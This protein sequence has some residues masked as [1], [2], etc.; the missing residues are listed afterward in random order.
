MY[1]TAFREDFP[2]LRRTVHGKCLAYLDNAATTQKPG[3]VIDAIQ[4]YY[5]ET[6]SN[7]H[8]AVHALA[9]EA[10]QAYEASRDRVAAFIHASRREEVIFTRGTTEGINLVAQSLGQRLGA[11]DEILVTQMEHHSNLVPWQ[12]LCAR[13]GARLRLIPVSDS[14][15][16]D[17][18]TLDD[19]LNE[20][21][22][23]V[24]LTHVSNLLGT[25][26]PV[27]SIISRAH[28]AGALVLIDAAQSVP[29]MPVD[30]QKMGADFLVFSAHKLCGPTGVGVLV[31]R[32]EILESMPPFL[33]GGEMIR[34]VDWQDSTYADLP[35]KFE[36]GTPHIAGVVGLHSALDYLDGI[37]M[38]AIHERVQALTDELVQKL[39]TLDGVTIYGPLEQRGGAVSFDVKG[40]H[41]HD[42][43]QYL[44]QQGVA[45][46]AGHMCCQPLVQRFGHHALSRASVYFYNLGEEIDQLIEAIQKATRFFT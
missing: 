17:L 23:I 27:E 7:V 2:I 25:L 4:R 45:I 38:Q 46:R 44:D 41:P 34:R 15:I 16:L 14:G 12:M 10:T 3:Q 9:D 5:L 22:R 18:E 31:G 21:T 28:Q 35:Y 20:R 13:N 43:S 19:L 42:L 40:V 33:G 24:S 37:G 29:H 39:L 32:K 30:M 26:N 36:A 11:G 1:S 8:R 6:N